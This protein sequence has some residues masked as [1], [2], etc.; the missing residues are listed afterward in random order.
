MLGHAACRGRS[1]RHTPQG[2]RPQGPPAILLRLYFSS[3]TLQA[4]INDFN[5]HLEKWGSENGISIIKPDPVFR[6]G[7]GEIDEDCYHAYGQ[8]QGSILIRLGATRLLRAMADQCTPLH[9]HINKENLR[10]HLQSHNIHKHPNKQ[11]QRT[12]GHSST[13]PAHQMDNDGWRRVGLRRGS[14]GHTHRPAR[15]PATTILLATLIHLGIMECETVTDC[16]LGGEA[17]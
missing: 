9:G 3:D 16:T 12:P 13:P 11:T 8:H 4:K 5:E 14:S 2:M 10:K 7:N 6:L 15:P 17:R 1:L